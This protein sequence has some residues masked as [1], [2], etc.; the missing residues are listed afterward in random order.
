MNILDSVFNSTGMYFLYIVLVFGAVCL[1]VFLIRKFVINKNKG[2]KK[3]IDEKQAASET[4]S[5]YLEDV[6][7]PEAQKQF[8]E[9][10]K[11]NED[12]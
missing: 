6:E 8:D 1:L 4:L 10:D 11:Q 5:R 2:D 12:K 9:Y 7:D 3:E